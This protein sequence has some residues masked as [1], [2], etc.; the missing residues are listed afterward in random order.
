MVGFEPGPRFMLT[1]LSVCKCPLQEPDNTG[2]ASTTINKKKISAI[3]CNMDTI[4]RGP[5][6]HAK[7]Q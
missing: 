7:G 3:V 4:G 5:W 1:K 6:P 2:K